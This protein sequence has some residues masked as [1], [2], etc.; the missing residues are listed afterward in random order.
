M[1]IG[2]EQETRYVIKIRGQVV[3]IPFQSRQLAENHIANLPQD[4]QV[5][6]EIIPIAPSGQQILME[7]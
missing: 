6:A 2:E 3:S 7:F 1:L 5:L 4:Q